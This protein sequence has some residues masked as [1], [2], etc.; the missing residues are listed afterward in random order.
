VVP[1]LPGRA[2]TDAKKKPRAGRGQGSKF[3]ASSMYIAGRAM[4][5]SG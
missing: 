2:P 3:K 5:Y 1:V 4:A